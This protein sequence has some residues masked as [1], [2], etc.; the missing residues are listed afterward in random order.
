MGALRGSTSKYKIVFFHHPPYSTAVH[1]DEATWMRLPYEEWGATL[2]LSG[3]QHVYERLERRNLTY[4]INGLGGHN[5]R[6]EI[7][8]C[9]TI[10]EG[11]RVR[12]NAAHGMMVAQAD[13]TSL[14]LCFYSVRGGEL[15]DNTT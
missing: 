4:I 14:R 6:Y 2:V 13:E 12:Y 9:R 7:T 11:S 8:N 5:W 10:A 15:I 1:D 3:H